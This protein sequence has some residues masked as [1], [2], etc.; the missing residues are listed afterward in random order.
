MQASKPVKASQVILSQS[1]GVA[2]ANLINFVHGGVIMRLVDSAGGLAAM[3]HSEGT[4]VTAAIDEMS[5]IEPIALGDLVTVRASVNDVGTTSME[6]GVRVETENVVTGR[7]AHASTAYLVFVALDSRGQKRLVPKLMAQTD[8]EKRRMREAK[9][10]R[11]ARLARR[12]SIRA[13]SES[14]LTG[15]PAEN[16]PSSS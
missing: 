7:K 12:E 14:A 15:P 3:K 1:M 16:E 11:Q 6:V 8:E 4:V 9:L 13:G 10:R 5:F 2:D